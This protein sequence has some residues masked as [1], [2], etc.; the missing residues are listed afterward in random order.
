MPQGQVLNG[1]REAERRDGNAS[2]ANHRLHEQAKALPQ[3][4]E[5]DR[6]IPAATSDRMSAGV[7][8]PAREFGKGF[9]FVRGASR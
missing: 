2:A 9:R 3:P 1:H 7:Q 4:M 8:D 6:M 5:R